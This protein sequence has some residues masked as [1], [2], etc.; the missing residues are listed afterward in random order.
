V[1]SL[2]RA[3]KFYFKKSKCAFAQSELEYLDHIISS[4][5]VAT[6]PYKTQAMVDWPVPTIVIELRGFL[7]LTRH[8]RKFVK[9]YGV[10]AKPLTKLLQK[11]QFQ[12]D[13]EAQKAFDHPT[14]ISSSL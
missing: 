10:L 11:K 1:L 6:D 7:G 4:K 9:G 8:Y 2:L 12:W 13:E 3:H 14:L 5:G